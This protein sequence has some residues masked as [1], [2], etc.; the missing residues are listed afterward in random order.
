M[1]TR[2]QLFRV[3]CWFSRVMVKTRRRRGLLNSSA[4]PHSKQLWP[5]SS[6]AKAK[7]SYYSPN[8]KEQT[9]QCD[10]KPRAA[11][12]FVRMLL[13]RRSAV[14]WARCMV[15]SALVIFVVPSI[16]WK[17]EGNFSPGFNAGLSGLGCVLPCGPGSGESAVSHKGSPALL[18]GGEL[19]AL[20]RGAWLLAPW[21]HWSLRRQPFGGLAVLLLLVD[22]GKGSALYKVAIYPPLSPT[23]G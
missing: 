12:V 6:S 17:A 2:K 1:Q 21:A 16:C 18:R 19:W 15:H 5:V 23:Y 7:S 3:L 22:P 20:S 11:C 8:F 9:A 10:H 13:H 14:G 4:E